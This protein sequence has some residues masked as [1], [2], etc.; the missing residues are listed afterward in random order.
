MFTEKHRTAKTKHGGFV[1]KKG[2]S[3]SSA[4]ISGRVV[5]FVRMWGKGLETG[6][7]ETAEPGGEDKV[8]TFNLASET[9][10]GRPIS[11][12]FLDSW[13]DRIEKLQMAG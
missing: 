12:N 2:F 5:C 10:E 4:N 11:V 9:P 8:Y 1:L 3:F 13:V 6:R 7:E